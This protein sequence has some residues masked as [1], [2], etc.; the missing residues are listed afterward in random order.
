MPDLVAPTP[1]RV[2]CRPKCSLAVAPLLD[3]RARLAHDEFRAAEGAHGVAGGGAIDAVPLSRLAPLQEDGE[4]GDE[5][6][7]QQVK[8]SLL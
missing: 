7:E 5:A 4:A 3:L 8:P 1:S 2:I 6:E